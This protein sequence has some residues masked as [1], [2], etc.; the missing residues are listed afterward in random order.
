MRICCSTVLGENWQKVSHGK[1]SNIKNNPLKQEI[2]FGKTYPS[3]YIKLVS[4]N[5]IYNEN[6]TSA[7]EIG[8]ITK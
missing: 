2:L 4:H 8:I 3:R 6:W 1:F 7:G 5:D